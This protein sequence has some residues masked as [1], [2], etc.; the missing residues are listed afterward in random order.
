M[1]LPSATTSWTG[2]IRAG[3][4][5]RP[6]RTWRLRQKRPSTIRLS[7]CVTQIPLRN[8]AMLAHQAVAVDHISGGRLEVGIG[9]GLRADPSYQMIG[10]DNWSD[11]ERVARLPEYA[12]ILH[13][14]MSS[15]VSTY[16]GEY[17]AI[18]GAV[19][20]PG[21]IQRPRPPIMIAAMG[22]KMLVHTARHADIWNSLSFAQ[23]FDEQLAQTAER[24]EM[25]RSECERI[26]RDPA[27]VL[28]SF[29]LFDPEARASGGAFSYY[30][31]EEDFA[32]RC[33]ALLELGFREVSIYYPVLEH[34]KPAF[35][36]MIQDVFP[37]VVAEF[38]D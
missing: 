34:Q 10:M 12:E 9:T 11:A 36:H 6:G 4:F 3:P 20:S 28:A 19:T 26:G 32:H 31:S 38:E 18:E 14:L 8:P 30:E 16:E 22:P 33:R 35:Q 13:R 27:E 25:L 1:W 37:S 7:T 23:S 2:L 15:A 21:P 24:V 5:S 29:T 17:Y